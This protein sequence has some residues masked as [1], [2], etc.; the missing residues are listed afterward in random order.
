M[1]TQQTVDALV[2]VLRRAAHSDGPNQAEYLLATVADDVA[3]ARQGDPYGFADQL[4][5][6]HRFLDE[7]RKSW[8]ERDEAWQR[9]RRGQVAEIVAIQA[10]IESILDDIAQA[11]RRRTREAT[12]KLPHGSQVRT[13][14]TKSI[15]VRIGDADAFVAALTGRE[16]MP[17]GVLVPQPATLALNAAKAYAKAVLGDGSGEV[18]PGVT[19][20][21]AGTVTSKVSHEGVARDD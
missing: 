21:P 11:H 10:H 17:D 9:E 18:L 13:T 12:L 8:A 19:V 20:I 14:E 16:G 15:D 4:A 2:D 7:R 5:E 3:R 6:A 1:D